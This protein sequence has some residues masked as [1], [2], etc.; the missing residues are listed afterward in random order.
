MIQIPENQ[1][2]DELC[3]FT[4]YDAE[5]GEPVEPEQMA[6][7]TVQPFIYPSL[8][9][10]YAF[11]DEGILILMSSTGSYCYI[12]KE[13]KYIIQFADTGKYLRW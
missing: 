10:C 7:K 2:I 3:G 4:V 9:D 11:T 12:A 5:T 1:L 13:G 8:A 6:T